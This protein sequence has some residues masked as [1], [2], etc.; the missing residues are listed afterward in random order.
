MRVVRG[1][2]LLEG[3]A[4]VLR[5]TAKV[6]QNSKAK[7]DGAV[8]DALLRLTPHNPSPPAPG[9]QA[10]RVH[11]VTAVC[12]WNLDNR[13]VP[14]DSGLVIERRPDGRAVVCNVLELLCRNGDAADTRR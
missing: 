5:I 7:V 13:P 9:S 3:G 12:A 1:A 14:L 6:M 11:R 8:A 10:G 2:V 4:V